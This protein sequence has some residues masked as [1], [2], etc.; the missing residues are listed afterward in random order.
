MSEGTIILI[1]VLLLGACI[2][3][4]MVLA[5]S[6]ARLRSEK[7]QAEKRWAEE[8]SKTQELLERLEA[9]K[10]DRAQL[11][12]QVEKLQE[13]AQALKSREDEAQDR[14][15]DAKGSLG[16][17]LGDIDDV[18]GWGDFEFP[19]KGLSDQET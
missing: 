9:G 17:V 2:I 16:E 8:T 14:I 18:E 11:Q 4:L 6:W 12:Q 7:R 1:L 3:G 5:G 19:E 15:E 13:E 10:R